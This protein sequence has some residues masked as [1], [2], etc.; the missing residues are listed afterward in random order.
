M[1]IA[2]IQK[3]LKKLNDDQNSD[4]KQNDADPDKVIN[5]DSN[6]EERISKQQEKKSPE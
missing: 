2:S 5:I 3:S 1:S 6:D 4:E